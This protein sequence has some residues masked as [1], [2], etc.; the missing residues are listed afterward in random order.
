MKKT[1]IKK[2]KKV[3]K[4]PCYNC[5][6]K[7]DYLLQSYSV[8]VLYDMEDNVVKRFDDGMDSELSYY[9]KE[10]AKKDGII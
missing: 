1:K 6:K 4:V 8:S 10:C 5:D 3:E 2:I 7:A 9:C